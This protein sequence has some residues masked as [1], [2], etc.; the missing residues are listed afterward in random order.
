MNVFFSGIVCVGV[1]LSLADVVELG[2]VREV[3]A[4]EHHH[5]GAGIDGQA[6][7]RSRDAADG[8][9]VTADVVISNIDLPDSD[10]F[11]EVA[12]TLDSVS[13]L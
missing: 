1:R 10:G 4:L 7:D 3:A 6:T 9:L 2:A 11:V 5:Q 8:A 13:T 12:G